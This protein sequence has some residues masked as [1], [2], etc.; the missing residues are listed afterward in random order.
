MKPQ[1][2]YLPGFLVELALVCSSSRSV[3]FEVA[4]ATWLSPRE[5]DTAGQTTSLKECLCECQRC[6]YYY[7]GVSWKRMSQLKASC[8]DRKRLLRQRTLDKMLEAKTSRLGN[9]LL[10]GEQEGAGRGSLCRACVC[11]GPVVGLGSARCRRSVGLRSYQEPFRNTVCDTTPATTFNAKREARN[12][13]S[14]S[15]RSTTM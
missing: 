10:R 5:A 13:L 11:H 6:Y 8:K 3:D 4:A 14:A 9:G 15:A 7:H 2:G 1:I 12:V